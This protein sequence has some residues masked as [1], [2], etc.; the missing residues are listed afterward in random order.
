MSFSGTS[1]VSN[2]QSTNPFLVHGHRVI[3]DPPLSLLEYLPFFKRLELVKGQWN[4]V[5][6]PT[7]MGGTRDVPSHATLH[8]SVHKRM[9]ACKDYKPRNQGLESLKQL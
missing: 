1:W 6:L 9:K 8:P 7:N 4:S 3:T 2:P 5:F